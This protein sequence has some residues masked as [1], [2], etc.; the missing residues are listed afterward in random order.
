MKHIRALTITQCVQ[1]SDGAASQYKS[2]G[3]F[4]DVSHALDDYAFPLE[5]CFF[6][7]HH[8]KGPSVG[9]SAVVKR[10]ASLPVANNQDVLKTAQ[11]LGQWIRELTTFDDHLG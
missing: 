9:E 1:W 2:K 7:S 3:P 4:C 8:G 11:H 6:G 10:M 5:R